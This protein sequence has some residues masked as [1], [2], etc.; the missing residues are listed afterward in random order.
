[1]KAV[2][3]SAEERQKSAPKWTVELTEGALREVSA[4][5]WTMDPQH[6]PLTFYLGD[7]AVAWFNPTHVRMWC[8]NGAVRASIPADRPPNT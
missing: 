8:R 6:A 2:W 3:A 7:D 4:D 1:M 5:R